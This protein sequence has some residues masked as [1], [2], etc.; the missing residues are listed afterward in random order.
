M[1]GFGV[2]TVKASTH[3][4]FKAGQRVGGMFGWQRYVVKPGKEVQPLDSE[5]PSPSHFLSVL[6]I[7]GLTAW[8][9]LFVTAQLKPTDVVVVSA[10]SGA[11]G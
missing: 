11:V 5:Y 4:G 6:G 1:N 9:G 3:P 2:G 7:S 8:V 10:A